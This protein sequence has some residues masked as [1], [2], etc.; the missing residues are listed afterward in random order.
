MNGIGI[1][2]DD[3]STASLSDTTDAGPD[4]VTAPHEQI[5]SDD[6]VEINI[7]G[8]DSVTLNSQFALA[9]RSKHKIRI[10]NKD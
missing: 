9:E 8:G 3:H 7:A 6:I 1:G 2:V 5:P 10:E 4:K